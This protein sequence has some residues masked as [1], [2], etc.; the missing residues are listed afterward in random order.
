MNKSDIAYTL[1]KDNTITGRVT[2]FRV[3]SDSM[4]PILICGDTVLIKPVEYGK[5]GIG[6]IVAFKAEDFIL[7]HR[8]LRK[9]PEKNGHFSYTTKGDSSF[10]FDNWS[11]SPDNLLGRIFKIN[12]PCGTV[13][14]DTAFWRVCGYLSSITSIFQ[15]RIF[16]IS[17]KVKK[18]LWKN[19]TSPYSGAVKKALLLPLLTLSN[20]ILS[21]NRAGQTRLRGRNS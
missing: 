3:V 10:D 6:D 7:V 2:D 1:L 12:K 9:I 4:S 20:L 16:R 11:I 19:K 5:L 14:L 8:I 17:V 18:R 21:L 15:A 13:N